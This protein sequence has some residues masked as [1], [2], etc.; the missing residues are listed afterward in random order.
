[1]SASIIA[2][3]SISGSRKSDGSPNSSG[4]CWAYLPGT[5]TPATL[6]ADPDATIVITQPLVLD[7]GGRVS[8]SDAPDGVFAAIPIRLYIEDSSTPA[9]VV[10]DNLFTPATATN[11]TLDNDGWTGPTEDDAWTALF[12]SLGGANGKYKSSNGATERTVQSKFREIWI[13]VKDFGAV[14]DGTAID[15]TAIQ[16]AFNFAKSLANTTTN[17]GSP[18]VWFPA[19]SYKIDQ[20]ITLSSAQ[21]NVR[22]ESYGATRILT[23]HASANVFSFTSCNSFEISGMRINC[24]SASSAAA[25]SLTDCNSVYLC[26]LLADSNS[27]ALFLTPIRAATSSSTSSMVTIDRCALTC[28]DDATARALE[29]T[30]TTQVSVVNSILQGSPNGVCME[31]AGVTGDV[32]VS[33]TYFTGTGKAMLW[34]A[35]MTGTRFRVFGNPSLGTAGFATV[36]DVTALS[37]LPDFRQWGNNVDAVAFSG[38]TGTALTPVL[39]EGK[40]IILSATSGGAGTVTVN[41]PAIL[42]GTT[43]T[44]VDLY[45]DFVFVNAAGGAVTWATN[46]IYVLNGATA[47][48]ST[49][50]HTIQVRFRWDRASSKFRECS[51]GDTVT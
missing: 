44:D 11:T 7:V 10:S 35:G 38:A 3:L 49:A 34:T 47:V 18:A 9:N 13:S 48:P 16:N 25:I 46:A 14:G 27:G 29:L 31:F 6:Y 39:Y 51:R 19:G 1:M 45:W 24:T 43:A 15:T 28:Q 22:G 33:S 42:P 41:A 5:T 21:V 20:A 26:D 2:S 50:A 36:F 23:T 30:S 12:A 37:T 8:P 4:R 17:L 32:T 40:E